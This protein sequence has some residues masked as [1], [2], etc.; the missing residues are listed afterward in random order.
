MRPLLF[1]LFLAALPATAQHDHQRHYAAYADDA[2]RAIKALS[3]QETTGLLEGRGLGLAMAAELN[4]YPGPLHVLELA[5]SLGLSP[6]QH[7]E[8]QRLFDGVQAEARPLGAQ[9]V[10]MERHLDALFAG[11]AATPEDVAR[12]TSHLGEARG[13]LRAVHLSA[14]IAMRNALTPNQTAAYDRLRGYTN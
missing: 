4:R 10:E 2:D 9:I 1:L 3:S 5:D 12:I 14:H 7:A 6:E 8:A 13:R 11:G